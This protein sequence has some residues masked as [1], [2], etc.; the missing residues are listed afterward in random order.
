MSGR[1]SQYL[2]SYNI[3]EK[4]SLVD[5]TSINLHLGS[6]AIAKFYMLYIYII[7]LYKYCFHYMTMG[8]GTWP[9]N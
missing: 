3:F 7:I 6:I 5:K 8:G 2:M 9:G 1:Y 4:Q